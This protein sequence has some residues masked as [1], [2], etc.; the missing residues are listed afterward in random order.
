ML[1][2]FPLTLALQHFKSALGYS[3]GGCSVERECVGHPSTPPSNCQP[4]VVQKCA[5]LSSFTERWI[6][7]R[8]GVGIQCRQ[9][10]ELA[11]SWG[12]GMVK[13]LWKN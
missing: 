4:P 8:L 12:W 10:V 7:G 6:P 9:F 2:H 5:R 11:D 1:A 3:I 13:V